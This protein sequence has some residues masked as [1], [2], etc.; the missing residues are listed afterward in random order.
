MT[1]TTLSMQDLLTAAQGPLLEP[2]SFQ[3]TLIHNLTRTLLRDN[4][5]PCLL[6]APTGSGKTFMLAR[7]LANI[8]SETGVVWFWFV[9]FVNL[10]AQTLDALKSNAS[11]LTPTTLSLG[12]NQQPAGGQVM[13]ATTQSVARA[14]WRNKGYDADGDDDTR[15]I[16]EWVKLAR[17]QPLKIGLVVDEAH[18]ALDKATEFGKFAQWLN[19]DF[20]LLATATPKDQRLL[21][22]MDSAGKSDYESFA[23]SRD[24]VVEA[25]LNKRYIEAVIY[26]LGQSLQS[27][28]DLKRTVLR[29][30][31]KRNQQLKQS[32]A[33]KNIPLTPLLL[34]QVANGDKT[35]EEAEQDLIQ[36]CKVPPGAIG[37]HSA[38]DP[39]PVMMAA[40][41][42]DS[43]K[44]VLIFKQSA[45]TGFDAPR[46]FVLASTKPVNDPDFAMQFI[47]RVMRVA[48]AMRKAY[49]D[50]TVR[51]PEELDSAYVYLADASAQRGFEQAV[52]TASVV[53][54]ELEGQ[55]EKL[56]PRRMASGA[57]VLTNKP[58]PQLPLSY[59]ANTVL[60]QELKAAEGENDLPHPTTTGP[61]IDLFAAADD[62]PLDEWQSLALRQVRSTAKPAPS[63]PSTQV[64]WVSHLAKHEIRVY[65]RRKDLPA[66]PVALQAERKPAFTQMTAISRSVAVKLDIP[67]HLADN[68]IRAARNQL[69]DTERHTELTSG[70]FHDEKVLIVTDRN[71]LAKEARLALSALPQTEEEDINEIL[72]VLASR[73][74]P[75]V[76]AKFEDFDPDQV[77][78]EKQLQR[79]ARDAANWVAKQQAPILAEALHAEIAAQAETFT[80]QPLPDAMLFASALPLSKS[81]RNLYGVL[82]PHKDEVSQ[83][84]QL[85]LSD[86]RA[87]LRD[88]DWQLEDGTLRA[89]NY[90]STAALNNE[91]LAFAKALDRSEF[92]RWWHRNPDRKPYSVRL[93]RGEHKNHFYPDFVICLEHYPGDEPLLRLIET[94]HDSKDAARKAKHIPTFYGKVL[95]LTQDQE[96]MKWVNDNGSLGD[97]VDLDDLSKLQDWLRKTRPTQTDI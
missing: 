84:D 1:D 23:V 41:A 94:K 60:H 44:E 56:L 72:A 57:V 91:E 45:G 63:A 12:R 68:A 81:P 22:F 18:I 76:R 86:D 62:Q 43:S 7:V 19:P 66:V 96:Q 27:V 79:M 25:R 90:D 74:L 34:V 80:A 52:Q 20:L 14:Q 88:S 36:L 50:R 42:S 37:K 89:G 87:L 39:D 35:V 71:A 53:K 33:E 46:A 28:A 15:T 8:S 83:L 93:V 6:R 16:A 77:P 5:P 17:S 47:G 49:P 38:D 67:T 10:V 54:S 64:E 30:A 29:Q 21:Q 69:K 9:P 40:I 92:V 75:M 31:W 97:V 58:T 13:I 70:Q 51:L 65:P 61:Q 24:D 3:S 95:F 4:R 85:L 11:D 55:T 82:P 73:L 26:D 32:L 78:E 2:E 48:L 59:E